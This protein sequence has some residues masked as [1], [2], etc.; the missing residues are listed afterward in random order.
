[1]YPQD[2]VDVCN[3][4]GVAISTFFV[5]T[6]LMFYGGYVLSTMRHSSLIKR[7]RAE[8]E[9]KS[10]PNEMGDGQKIV[11]TVLQGLNYALRA[12][13]QQTSMN[14][15]SSSIVDMFNNVINAV[16]Q[17]DLRTDDSSSSEEEEEQ[18]SDSY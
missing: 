17:E 10:Q 15:E 1:M 8:L 2:C 12:D 6:S 11:N 9:L 7:L 18:V 13:R 3:T 5:L 4:G 16:H 14:S